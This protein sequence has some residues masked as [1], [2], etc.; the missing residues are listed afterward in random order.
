VGVVAQVTQGGIIVPSWR[1]P[2]KASPTTPAEAAP[3]SAPVSVPEGVLSMQF[4]TLNLAASQ[5]ALQLYRSWPGSTAT[6]VQAGVVQPYRGHILA[7]M[8]RSNASITAGQATFQAYTEGVVAGATL[9]WT[10][11]YRSTATFAPGT[12]TF[13]A[14][15]ELDVRVTTDAS[16]APVTSDIEIILIASFTP[17]S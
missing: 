6:L 7:M 2:S 4:G 10:S 17:G 11:G 1:S 5:S 14:G 15:N 8:L 12:Y 16:F 13:E 9:T 3:V